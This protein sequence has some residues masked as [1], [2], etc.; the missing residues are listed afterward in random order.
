MNKVL[1]GVL[2]MRQGLSEEDSSQDTELLSL[3][4]DTKLRE[5]C[6]WHLGDPAWADRF[7]SWADACGY[8]IT[9]KKK[10]LYA[11]DFNLSS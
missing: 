4:V 9:L 3:S 5:I 11:N 6:A 7:L 8:E 2:R 1:L 10:E